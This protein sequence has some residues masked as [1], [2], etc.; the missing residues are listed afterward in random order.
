MKYEHKLT[1]RLLLLLSIILFS[2]KLLYSVLFKITMYLVK[3]S[4]YNYSLEQIS[5]SELLVQ[6]RFIEFAPACIVFLAYLLLAILILVTKDI[7]FKTSVKM[8]LI[9]SLVIL[10]ANVLRIRLL[11]W[12]W[13]NYGQNLFEILHLMF[14]KLVLGVFVI[15]IWIFLIKHYKIKT[16]PVYSDIKELLKYV[17][18]K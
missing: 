11:F 8:F 13:I 7:D 12:V 4:L 15:L 16:I 3:L 9:G 2:Y 17:N 1:I 14:W 6:G 10:A 5:I 18:K